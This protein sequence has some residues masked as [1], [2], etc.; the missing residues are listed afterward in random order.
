MGYTGYLKESDIPAVVYEFKPGIDSYFW[1]TAAFKSFIR[2]HIIQII[3]IIHIRLQ[4]LY[5]F[6]KYRLN[7]T[8]KG[9]SIPKI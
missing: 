1:D 8:L 6:V 7:N 3:T 2:P 4:P 5:S 9:G